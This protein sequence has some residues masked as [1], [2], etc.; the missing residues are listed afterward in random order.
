M[1]FTLINDYHKIKNSIATDIESF[2]LQITFTNFVTAKV[3]DS[4]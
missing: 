2:C 1:V 3:M 4:Y